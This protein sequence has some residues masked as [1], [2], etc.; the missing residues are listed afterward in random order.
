MDN[1]HIKR[2]REAAQAYYHAHPQDARA[3][4][5][6]SR[7]ESA[8][9]NNDDALKYAEAAVKIDPKNGEYHRQ[10][11]GVYGDIGE[12]ASMLKQ[13]GLAR[14]CRAE[15]DAAVALNP[16]D[17]E[18]LDAQVDYYRDAPGVVG[19]DKKKA[20]SIAGDMVKINPARGYLALAAIA[21]AEKDE[22][23]A[24]GLYR[25]AVEAD[26]HS[27][28][29]LVALA[30][31]NLT[32]N[33][34]A[35]AEKLASD[36]ISVNPDRASA[37]VL[38]AQNLVRQNRPKDVAALLTKAETAIPDNLAPYLVAGRAM[39]EQGADLQTAEAYIRKYL[40]QPPEPGWPPLAGAHWSLGLLDEKRG[41]KT[42]AR[43]EL[44]TALRLKPDFEP[45]KRDLKRLR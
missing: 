26:S 5:L 13:F 6:M 42:Q 15:I 43:A 45:A 27:Y 36:A 37:Y 10:L 11:A 23:K 22:T 30:R 35:E 25:K 18:N 3:N 40:G 29:A 32:H 7:V 28:E 8:F 34:L 21:R 9:G 38:A 44:E 12:K 17:V 16:K 2:A 1:G 19:G 41:D 33:D 31:Y 20:E 39:L 14:K 24:A 4:Y